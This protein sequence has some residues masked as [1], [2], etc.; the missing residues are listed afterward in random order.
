MVF[1]HF[2]TFMDS[3]HFNTWKDLNGQSLKSLIDYGIGA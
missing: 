3:Q 1:N 2:I